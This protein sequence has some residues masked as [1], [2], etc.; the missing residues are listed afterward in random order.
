MKKETM[1]NMAGIFLFYL[2]IVLGVVAI[3]ARI[4]VI[5]EGVTSVSLGN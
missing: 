2:L 3:N 5:N 4:G 1:R